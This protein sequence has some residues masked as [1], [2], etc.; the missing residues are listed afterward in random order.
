VGKSYEFA[1]GFELPETTLSPAPS[2]RSKTSLEVGKPV[3]SRG[4]GD[5]APTVNAYYDPQKNQ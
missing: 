5:D 4:V 2:S 3:R 1:I